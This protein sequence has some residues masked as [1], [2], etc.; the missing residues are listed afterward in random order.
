MLMNQRLSV[1]DNGVEKAYTTAVSFNNTDTF[2]IELE[3]SAAPQNHMAVYV[4]NDTTGGRPA[5]PTLQFNN[6]GANYTPVAAGTA[7]YVNFGAHNVPANYTHLYQ[8]L[9]SVQQLQ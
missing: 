9:Y 5:T 4:W 8:T 1:M 7:Q 2:A 3:I 6:G